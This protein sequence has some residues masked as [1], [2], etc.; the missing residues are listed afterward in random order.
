MKK[1]SVFFFFLFFCLY[2]L[3]QKNT[4]SGYIKDAASGEGLIGANVYI[5]AL[6][7]GTVTNTYGFYSITVEA[8]SIAI[9]YSFVGFEPQVNKI[10]L[11]KDYTINVDL[12]LKAASVKAVTITDSRTRAIENVERPQVGIIDIPV[13]DIKEL[14]AIVGEK[15]VLKSLQLLPG[16]QS[17]S[18]GTAG[19]YVRGGGPDQN[20]IMLDEAVVYNPF[21]LFG[22]FSVF[23][24]DALKNVNLIKGGFPAE[25]GGRLS[26]ILDMSMKEGNMKKFEGE[27][28]VGL[29][30]SRLTLQ[31]PIIKD[32]ASFMVAGRRTYADLIARG[33]APKRLKDQIPKV[34]FYDLNAKVNYK[35]SDK[36]RLYLSGYYGNDV[37]KFNIAEDSTTF[38]IP[39]GNSTLTARW[40]HLFNNKLFAN[41]SFIYSDYEFQFGYNQQATNT[42]FTL[43]SGIRDIN[44]KI[45]FDYYPNPKHRIKFGANYTYHRFTPS[46]TTTRVNSIS[47]NSTERRYVHESAVYFNDE[48]KLSDQFAIN[49][50]IRLPLFVYKKTNYYG[51]EPRF[52]GKY[53]IDNNTSIKGSYS[54]MN[55]YVHLVTNST[56]SFPWDIWI[57]SSDVI[58]PQQANQ[59]S[60]GI[61]KN[62]KD[63]TY[64]TSI[65]GYYKT[66]DNM[67]EYKEGANIFEDS[68]AIEEKIT[69]GNG[70]AY[71][72]EFFVRKREGRLYGWVGYTL[73]WTNRKFPE[74]NN[75]NVF[76]AK[77]DRRND[78]SIAAFYDFNKRWT[79][80]AVFVYG[81]GNS[82]TLPVGRFAVPNL[83]GQWNSYNTGSQYTERNGFKLRP[84]NR[85]DIGIKY[86]V[87]K[88]RHINEWRFDIYNSYSRR[89][90]YFVYLSDEN[91]VNTNG[92]RFVAKQVSLFPMLPS[93]SY[94]FKF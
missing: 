9:I 52:T 61:F 24:V 89:N 14:P 39:W 18:E 25:Y 46:A 20:L 50:G 94:N 6:Q 34:Y 51:V 27:G 83:S 28:G 30:S 69:F 36:D 19:Y 85:L 73:S 86:T 57:P 22:F 87:K 74:L 5:S 68:S 31:G 38:N 71:G 2:C 26:S 79:F 47:T 75:G 42:E 21:H 3:A 90:P 13:K 70:E 45:D 7:T 40:N 65:E 4:I 49:A 55:Q 58:K 72:A 43:K 16:V 60:L 48:I 23:N 53:Q 64:E 37:A 63:H 77:Y 12:K 62:L 15:D 8:D 80:S 44:G 92:R 76:T 1:T 11:N 41:T 59:V 10:A 91:D 93:F 78:L 54:L 29:I 33:V 17:G 35:F 81:S 32:K 66:M 88:E 82:I 56:L 67:I 84:Y